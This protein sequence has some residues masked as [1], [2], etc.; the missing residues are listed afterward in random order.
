[1]RQRVALY[2]DAPK[3]AIVIGDTPPVPWGDGVACSTGVKLPLVHQQC[4]IMAVLAICSAW[5]TCPVSHNYP[6]LGEGSAAHNEICTRK[7]MGLLACFDA[8][9]HTPFLLTVRGDNFITAYIFSGEPRL[10]S[11]HD[12]LLS[13]STTLIVG[14]INDVSIPATKIYTTTSTAAYL[15]PAFNAGNGVILWLHV[16][17]RCID[18]PLP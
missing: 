5:L 1:M 13:D 3:T 16:P 6:G 9:R 4:H 11:H 14:P 7:N 2:I 12:A 17:L 18:W 10:C 8:G 15:V